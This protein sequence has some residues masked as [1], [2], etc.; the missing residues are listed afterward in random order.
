MEKKISNYLYLKPDFYRIEDE[1]LYIP[2]ENDNSVRKI[3]GLYFKNNTFNAETAIELYYLGHYF[4]FKEEYYSMK[5][6]YK[7]AVKRKFSFAMNILAIYYKDTEKKLDKM[8]KYYNMAIEQENCK[9]MINLGHYYKSINNDNEMKKYYS[10]TLNYGNSDGLVELGSCFKN[11]RKIYYSVAIEKY[12]NSEAMVRLGRDY[13]FC[14]KYE[15]MKK[16]LS[17]AIKSNNASAM[18]WYGV[19][20]KEINNIIEMEKYYLMAL[21]LGNCVNSFEN[22]LC[23]YNNL[24][25]NILKTVELGILYHHLVTNESELV[26]QINKVIS[27]KLYNENP[28]K[29]AGLLIKFVSDK[30]DELCEKILSLICLKNYF[31]MTFFI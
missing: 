1:C 29:F 9:A 27:E 24:N 13:Y 5:K 2:I 15:K 3:Y 23:Y 18:F 28:I 20:C 30:D 26:K 14:G 31:N 11:M 8:I 6:C 25:R 16:Y 12:N 21:E 4:K 19:Y 7:Q 22:L 17:M 10:M